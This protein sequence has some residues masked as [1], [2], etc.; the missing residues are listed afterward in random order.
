MKTAAPEKKIFLMKFFIYLTP[1]KNSLF[2]F[3]TKFGAG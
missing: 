3:G 1:K 2:L